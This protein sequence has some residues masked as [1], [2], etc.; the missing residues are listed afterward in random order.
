MPRD[1]WVA[2]ARIGRKSKANRL[3]QM[4]PEVSDGWSCL[5]AR[6]LRAGVLQPDSEGSKRARDARCVTAIRS[7]KQNGVN[8]TLV[9]TASTLATD[10][11]ADDAARAPMAFTN[12]DSRG[13]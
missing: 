9:V 7:F 10:D 11:D 2:A 1:R 8:R 13:Q 12:H 6:T 5:A 4:L 3:L